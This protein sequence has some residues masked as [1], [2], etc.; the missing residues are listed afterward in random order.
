MISW[1]F[2]R[3]PALPFFSPARSVTAHII[4]QTE[5]LVRHGDSGFVSAEGPG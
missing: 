2:G 1:L 4:A 3:C 5:G